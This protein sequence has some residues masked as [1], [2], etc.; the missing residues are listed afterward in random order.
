MLWRSQ[1]ER[2]R[3]PSSVARFL[4]GHDPS[5]R[6]GFFYRITERGF[7]AMFRG[8][9]W[10]LGLVLRHRYVMGIVFIGMIGASVYMFKIVPKGFIPE[11]D[12]DQV[13]LSMIAAQ[14]TSFY[15]MVEYQR[16]LADVVRRNPNVLTFMT[17]VGGGFGGSGGNR[18][19]MNVILK[20][21]RQRTASSQEVVN[22]LRPQI[23]RFP[24]F[25]AFLSLPPAIRVGGLVFAS[26]QLP[27][28]GADTTIQAQTRSDRVVSSTHTMISGAI[29]TIGVTC[30][31]TA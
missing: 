11:Q 14:G 30:R 22:Q 29:A 4:R 15:K 26:G 28:R 3:D 27:S 5:R 31:I 20:P 12:N 7:D 24:G 1:A 8:Y 23:S 21:R 9:A 18:S 2:G 6:R 10:S 17:N 19:F 25:R 13:N 16:Q